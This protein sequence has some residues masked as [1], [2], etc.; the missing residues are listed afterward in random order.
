MKKSYN[1]IPLL[2][3]VYTIV[4]CIMSREQF[5]ERPAEFAA[6]IAVEVVIIVLL[7]YVLRRRY[8]FRQELRKQNEISPEKNSESG[9]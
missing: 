3:L 5:A 1:L 2:L 7:R 8:R 4:M 6:I 9:K